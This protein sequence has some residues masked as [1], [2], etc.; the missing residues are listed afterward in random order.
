MQV[1]RIHQIASR[2]SESHSIIAGQQVI[3]HVTKQSR[4]ELYMITQLV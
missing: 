3:T 2:S 1:D 4:L